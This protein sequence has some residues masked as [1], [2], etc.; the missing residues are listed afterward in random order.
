MGKN[1]ILWTARYLSVFLCCFISGAFAQAAT[2][3][4]NSPFDAAD[5]NPGDAMC[6]TAPGNGVCTLR[7]AIEEA[8]TLGAGN[9]TIILPPNTYLLTLANELTITGD[10]TIT[11]GGASTTIID[12]NK[13]SRVLTINF[14]ITV[15]ISGVTIRNGQTVDGAGGIAN[16]G[17]LSLTNS[18][19]SGN[20]SGSGLNSSS[21]GG[22]FNSGTLTLTNSTVS[23][24]S[25]TFEGG[26]IG[27]S[28]TLTLTNSTVSGNSGSFDGGGIVNSGT[29][30]LT[31]STVS[32]NNSGGHNGAFGGGIIN[33]GTLTLTNSTVSG[34]STIGG[35]GGIINSGTLTLT[36]S[37]VSGNRGAFGSGGGIE[38]G[39]TANLFNA[40]IANN[41]VGVT[42]GGV[43]N[44]AGAIFNFQNTI[45]AGNSTDRTPPPICEGTINSTGNNLMGS[46]GNCTV[47]GGGV[48]VADPKLGPL[49]NN[50]GPT[51]THALVA[52]S[53]AIDAGNPSGCRDNAGTLLPTDQ[54]GFLRPADGNNDGTAGCDIGAYEANAVIGNNAAF[55]FQQYIDFFDREPGAGEVSAWVSALDSGLS[56]ADLIEVFMNS[57]EF[58]FEGK[59]ITQTYLGILTRD[60]DYAGFRGWLGALLVGLSREQIVQVFLDSGEFQSSFGSNLT[61]GQFVE[62]MY[63]NILL[64]SS[65]PGGFSAWVGALNNGQLTKAQMAL[66]FLDSGEFQRL[67]VSQNRVDISLLYFDMLQRDPDAG[68]F[69]YWV[70]VLNSGVPLTSV[71]DGF[72]NSPEYRAGF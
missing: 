50:G 19:V 59:F 23:G 10:L 31:N 46:L 8:N 33:S 15:S 4:V 21:G 38:N 56:K 39:G 34:N 25:T 43:F 40:T 22:I 29:L 2:F 13:S 32:G 3:T 11:G 12:G 20:N 17:I 62:R 68:G 55:V 9:D 58:R 66:R 54:R 35:G 42:G 24:N 16:S 63:N 7:A 69:S 1:R 6:E 48:T 52:G 64:R 41:E 30:T 65:D 45:L 37:T 51:Q 14:G 5:A 61:N 72:L 44:G 26:G 28:G 36:N 71:I 60:A 53:P 18:T 27:N 47:N 49:Q 67:F 70:E 57:E